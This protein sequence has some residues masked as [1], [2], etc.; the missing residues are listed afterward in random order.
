MNIRNVQPS[1]YP[2]II[3]VLDDW[4]GGRKMRNMLPRLFFEHFCETSFIL[5]EDSQIAAFLVG[6]LSQ[7]QPKEAYIHFVGVHPQYRKCGYGRELYE[8]FFNI[9]RQNNRSLVRC[10]TSP[11]NSVSIAFHTRMGFWIEPGDAQMNGVG[12]DPDHDGPGEHRIKF[13]LQI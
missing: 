2:V 11:I 3:S 10:V 13:Y 5:E 7:S 4:W 8:C 1:D 9:M 12:Y 6:F